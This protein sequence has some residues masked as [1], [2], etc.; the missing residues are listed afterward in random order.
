VVRTGVV[1]EK[2]GGALA[3]ILPVFQLYGGGPLGSG[4]QFVSWIHRDDLVELFVRA[5]MEPKKYAG[6][7]NGTAPVPTTMDGLCEA[8][9]K[10][11]DRPNWLPVP[12]L[13]LRALLGEGA[14]VVL[15]GQKVLPTRTRELGFEFKYENVE[16]AL[17]A[18]VAK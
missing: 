12:G 11:T 7:V 13:A 15:D 8:V 10:A 6:V 1:L 5:L 4:K 14:T 2:G 16:E 9:A 3:K 17:E 18:I